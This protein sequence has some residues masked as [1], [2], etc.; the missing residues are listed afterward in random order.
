ML[1]MEPSIVLPYDVLKNSGHVDKF[2][3]F[4]LT[5]GA[6]SVRADH[7]IEDKLGEYHQIPVNFS[8][9]H[10]LELDKIILIG[11]DQKNKISLK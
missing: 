7:L 1:E 9:E 6:V 5:D 3:D 8:E 11:F 4:I 10:L 2:C